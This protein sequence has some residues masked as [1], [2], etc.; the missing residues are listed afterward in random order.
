MIEW[1]KR[2]REEKEYEDAVE[3]FTKQLAAIESYE[4]AGGGASK[5]QG[6]ESTNA[7]AEIQTAC[8][9]Q[10]TE[11]KAEN[12]REMTQMATEFAGVINEQ[13]E[14]IKSLRE[15][16]AS[17]ENKLSA[18]A[19]VTPP[20]RSRRVAYESD[21][22]TEEETPPRRRRKENKG[23]S[24]KEKEAA[25]KKAAKATKSKSEGKW[26]TANGY[27][28]GTDWKSVPYNLRR[29]YIKMR[30]EYW[31]TGTAAAKEDKKVE[32]KRITDKYD[33]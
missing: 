10:I 16:L 6:F 31:A 8:V 19:P 15:V 2:P 1:N 11:N 7:V 26:K 12:T 18:R 5:R 27:K 13:K 24:A 32:L 22:D 3:Y 29:E 21:S 14:Q 33:E 25:K 30:R 28:A 4:A 20:R 23:K 17:I 9:N